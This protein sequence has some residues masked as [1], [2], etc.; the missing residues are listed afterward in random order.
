MTICQT[1]GIYQT[2]HLE[3]HYSFKY[4]IRKEEIVDISE[5]S[6]QIFREGTTE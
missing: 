4:Y 2:W 3:G 1:C 5:L 6:L